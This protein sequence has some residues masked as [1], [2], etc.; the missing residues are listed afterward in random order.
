MLLLLLLLLFSASSFAQKTSVEETSVSFLELR[1]CKSSFAE[2]KLTEESEATVNKFAHEFAH[3]ESIYESKLKLQYTQESLAGKHY[4]YIQTI[5]NTIVYNSEVKVNTNGKAVVLSVFDNSF[6]PK[7]FTDKNSSLAQAEI[8]VKEKFQ[9]FYSLKNEIIWF[10]LSETELAKAYR[11]ELQN[12]ASENLEIITNGREILYK[13]D[14]NTYA[15]QADSTAKGFVFMPDPLTSSGNVYGGS[16][17]DNYDNDSP[18]LT[19]ERKEVSLSVEFSNNVFK[20]KNSFVQISDFDLPNN[21]PATAV[22][23]MFNF[24]R[25]NLNFEQVNAFYHIT[26][27]GKHIKSMGFNCA[28]TLVDVDANALNGQ[29]NSFFATNYNPQRLYFGIGGVD[30]AED[31]DV[32]V[33]EYS[34][35]LSYNASPQSN[36]GNERLALDE[37]F[38]DYNAASYSRVINDFNWGWVYNWDGHNAF[39]TGRVVNS[40]KTYPTNLVNNIY[41]DGEIWSS[42]LMQLWSDIGKN[43]MDK[44][45][46]Q[47][48]YGYAQNI[49]FTDAANLLLSA[50]QQLFNGLHYCILTQRM[51]ERGVLPSGKTLCTNAIAN[52]QKELPVVLLQT[53]DGCIVTSPETLWNTTVEIIDAAGKKIHT[54]PFEGKTIIDGKH[55][56]PGIYFVKVSNS[57]SSK[58]LKWFK[59]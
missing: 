25:S 7:T 28:N 16:F 26:E 20:L 22:L 49:K 53:P 35:F 6:S 5:G 4:S 21:I 34:H 40:N 27:I 46:V 56:A 41:K 42:M 11:F 55:F 31:A 50:D 48:H 19:N 15:A 52:I 38:G 54:Q 39:W 58:I 32:I 3:V 59:Q 8:F 30:D 10:P 51:F 14:L 29:D 43:T 44:L 1:N 33:H 18:W 13:R 12:A 57:N 24:S 17:I 37:A 47:A 9:S 23:P 36:T 2:T 45:I